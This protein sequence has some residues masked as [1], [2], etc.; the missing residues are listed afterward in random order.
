M[1]GRI[2][3]GSAGLIA[4]LS[5]AGLAAGCSMPSR[6]MLVRA[7][8]PPG[9]FGKVFGFL[10]TGFSFAGMLAPIVYGLVM[11]HGHPRAVFLLSAAACVAAAVAVAIGGRKAD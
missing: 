4:A 1:S 3:L 6:D 9:S 8:T 5:M 7:V 2:D 10:S 11:D